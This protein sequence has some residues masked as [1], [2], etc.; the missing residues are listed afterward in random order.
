M[1]VVTISPSLKATV[2]G[3]YK[4]TPS[5]QD[6][7]PERLSATAGGSDV[8]DQ[9]QTNIFCRNSDVADRFFLSQELPAILGSNG[10]SPSIKVKALVMF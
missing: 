4:L 9:A 10:Q 7:R 5:W 3:A 8:A 2:L 1:R 6:Y